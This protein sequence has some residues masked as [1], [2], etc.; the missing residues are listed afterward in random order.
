MDEGTFFFFYLPNHRILYSS[1]SDFTGLL[2][3]VLSIC[4]LLVISITTKP[5]GL[6]II[7]NFACQIMQLHNGHLCFASRE[8]EGSSFI[9]EF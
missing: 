6:D 9:L 4:R 7:L 8:G 5:G 2:L 3:A 1:L